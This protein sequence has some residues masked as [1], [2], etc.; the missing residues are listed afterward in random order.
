MKWMNETFSRIVLN[1]F[2]FP[3]LFQFG[4]RSVAI[5]LY[6]YQNFFF[7]LFS[8]EM[9]LECVS[10]LAQ[11]RQKNGLSQCRQRSDSTHDKTNKEYIYTYI[12]IH[13]TNDSQIPFINVPSLNV[14]VG[15]SPKPSPKGGKVKCIVT[16]LIAHNRIR[17]ILKQENKSNTS[18][19]FHQLI[20]QDFAYIS[21]I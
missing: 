21:I 13:N 9:S 14:I 8:D 18:K 6:F 16:I 20:R 3:E 5:K 11:E 7:V 1:F 12:C 10:C 4:R 15:S 17:S 19:W 2:L